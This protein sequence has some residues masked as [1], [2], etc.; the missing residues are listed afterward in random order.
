M[1]AAAWSTFVLVLAACDRSPERTAEVRREPVQATPPEAYATVR[2]TGGVLETTLTAANS[3]I[4]IG[5]K[6]FSSMVY[7]GRYLP[8]VLRVHRGDSLKLH[9]VNRLQQK[10]EVTNLHYHGTQVSPKAPSDDIFIHVDP[11]AEY[12]YRLYF[13]PLHDRGL[14]WY[15]PHP[16]GESEDQVLGG[17][18]GVLV[19]EGFLEGFYPWLQDVPEEILMLKAVEMPGAKDGDPHTKNINGQLDATFRIRPGELQF[20]RVANIAADA[21]FN[22]RIDGARMWL[23][24][25]DA[26]PLRRPQRVDSV[27]LP[28]GARAEVILEGPAAGR[29]AVRHLAYDTGPQGDPN[30]AATL[31][32]LVSAGP[33]VDRRADAARLDNPGGDVAAVAQDIDSLR[34][35]V[36]TRRRTFVFSESAD[37]DTFFVNRK[38]FDPNRV[39]TQVRLGD[40]EEW[41][42][43][44]TTGEV[45]AFHIHQTDFLVTEVN[46]VPQPA[47][48]LHDTV[49]LPYAVN[50][51]PGVVKI[52][53]P[54]T[55]PSIVGKFVYHCHILEHEDG[56]MMAT[57]QVNPP[58]TARATPSR[59]R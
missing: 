41:T 25:S 11:G 26:D 9:L 53:I 15:H 37:G 16:H 8:P 48:G 10:D 12:D 44:N 36:I 29:Y 27:L 43:E 24:A 52:I 28:P 1:A 50:G 30:P 23:L 32:T 6:T 56:G 14:F 58:A 35:H 49:N 4:T 2:S 33:P 5:G 59:Q 34:T 7:N 18:S 22:L 47:N 57:L 21:Y 54:F 13:P 38:Q 39:D 19:V 42:V 51:R 20:W 17:M 55:E 45:H 3:P 31:G 46:G 40:V